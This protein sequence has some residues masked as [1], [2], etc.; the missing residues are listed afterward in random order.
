MSWA[1]LPWVTFARAGRGANTTIVAGDRI[2]IYL[3]DLNNGDQAAATK[4]LRNW[5]RGLATATDDAGHTDQAEATTSIVVPAIFL[6]K[7]AT[8]EAGPGKLVQYTLVVQ[9][10]GTGQAT[11]VVVRSASSNGNAYPRTSSS[12]PASP[13]CAS[14]RWPLSTSCSALA[15]T[16]RPSPS[17]PFRCAS[18]W[19]AAAPRTA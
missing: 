5:E 9:N 16:R 3:D 19:T 15:R 17:A 14:V 7:L 12:R 1:L 18:G 6:D 4:I 10:T 13:C 8:D 11:G 2:D